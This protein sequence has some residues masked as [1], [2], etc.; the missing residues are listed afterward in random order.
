[1]LFVHGVV[2]LK[3]TRGKGNQTRSILRHK[4]AVLIAN[5]E[6]RWQLSNRLNTCMALQGLAF[7]GFSDF[8]AAIEWLSWVK[9]SPHQPPT[10]D[11]IFPGGPVHPVDP[12]PIRQINP[13]R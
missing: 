6:E 10:Q 5:T 3:E 8:E 1:V 9:L 13:F 12:G 4:I 11:K 2:L 7:E